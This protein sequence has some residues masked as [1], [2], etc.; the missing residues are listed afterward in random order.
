[1]DAVS[2]P[3][4][5]QVDW[6]DEAGR[7]LATLPRRE[8]RR[9]NLLHRVTSTFVFDPDGR[10]FVHRRT[11]SK[12]VY[13]GLH[14]VAVGGTVMS[15]ESFT[16]NARRELEEEL[17]V[18]GV[19]LYWLFAHRFQDEATNSRIEVFAC[20]YGGA[21]TFQPEEVD[22]GFWAE[23]PLVQGLIDSERVCPDSAQAWRLYREQCQAEG[24][25]ILRV[26][27][28]R[29]RPLAGSTAS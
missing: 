5:E 17:G 13:P 4:D 20:V 29:L 25:F 9:R 10:L 2:S 7:T 8:I 18:R 14:D 3:S 16:S 6:I 27:Q 12:D 15:G 23:L 11:K 1:M 22:E 26:A 19:P 21:M 24:D 28:G